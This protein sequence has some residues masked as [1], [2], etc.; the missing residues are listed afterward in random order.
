M[1]CGSAFKDKGV[2]PMLDA[3]VDYLPSPEDVP[4]IANQHGKEQRQRAQLNGNGDFRGENFRHRYII[5]VDPGNTQVS[6]QNQF[7]EEIVQLHK[8]RLIQAH[9]VQAILDLRVGHFLNV[10]EIAINGHL[11]NQD[12]HDGQNDK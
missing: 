11:A 6:V 2:Q 10:G 8:N 3:V 4:S 7:L 9:L 5:P 12:E 1:L